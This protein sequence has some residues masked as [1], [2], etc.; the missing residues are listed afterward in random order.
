VEKDFVLLFPA[1][2]ELLTPRTDSNSATALDSTRKTAQTDNYMLLIC[3]RQAL[4]EEGRPLGQFTKEFE[5]I[6]GI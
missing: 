3:F 1:T 4:S 5:A 2:T 6:H